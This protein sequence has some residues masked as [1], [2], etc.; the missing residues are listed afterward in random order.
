MKSLAVLLIALMIIGLGEGLLLLSDLGSAPWTVLSQGIA[1]KGCFSV[2][3][4]SFLISGVVMLMWLPLKLKIGLGTVLNII[5]IVFCFGLTTRIF[6]FSQFVCCRGILLLGIG[7]A[8]YLTCH[9]GAG[10]RD[11]LMVGF[12][13]HFR[14]NVGVVRT[15][16]ETL[17]CTFGV[18]LFA[19]GIGWGSQFML[20]LITW[21]PHSSYK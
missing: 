9:Q 3:W 14:L 17:V 8:F 13:L 11:G 6:I 7:S 21:L 12:C 16:M 15:T 1:L 19:L 20:A 10:P 5:V 18:L 4:A 2:G